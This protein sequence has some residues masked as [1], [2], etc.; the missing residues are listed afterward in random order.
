[1]NA[2]SSFVTS[3]LRCRTLMEKMGGDSLDEEAD[4][5]LSSAGVDVSSS[6]SLS[7]MLGGRTG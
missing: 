1:M 4:I 7:S 3:D 2:R 6:S 5:A